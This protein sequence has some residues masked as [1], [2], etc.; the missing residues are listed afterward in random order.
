[1]YKIVTPT[2]RTVFFCSVG[3]NS[4]KNATHEKGDALD[5]FDDYMMFSIEPN[6][7]YYVQDFEIFTLLLSNTTFKITI[8]DSVFYVFNTQVNKTVSE[9]IKSACLQLNTTHPRKIIDCK[10][11]LETMWNNYE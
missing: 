7:E 8:E 3:W 9:C 11:D 2:N 10:L 4:Y 5:H 1:M 6:G